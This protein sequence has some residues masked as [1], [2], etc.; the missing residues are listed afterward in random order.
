MIAFLRSGNSFGIAAGEKIL[1]NSRLCV[2]VAA[3]KIAAMP[4]SW[5]QE[6]A[7]D[8]DST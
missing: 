5:R 1:V 6:A 8:G 3:R 4:A 2:A 7:G